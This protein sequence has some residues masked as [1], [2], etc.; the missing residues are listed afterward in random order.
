M[1]QLLL[2]KIENLVQNITFGGSKPI[3]TEC[4]LSETKT[5]G[6][7]FCLCRPLQII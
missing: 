4:D 7:S 6:V 1:G 3:E 2:S 5:S